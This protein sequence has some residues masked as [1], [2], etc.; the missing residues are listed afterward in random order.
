MLKTVFKNILDG[1]KNRLAWIDYARGIAIILVLYRHV[2]EGIKQ[3]GINV[4]RWMGLEHANIVFFSFRMPLFFIVSGVFM[5]GSL[6]KRGIGGFILNKAKLI[7]YPY[8]LWASL[9][10]TLQ[11]VFSKYVNGD[12]K[13]SDYLYILYAPREIEQFWYLYALFNVTILYALVKVKLNLKPIYQFILGAVMYYLSTWLV[14]HKIETYFIYDILHYYVF[15]A[16]G[17]LIADSIR[18]KETIAILSSWKTVL[19]LLPFFC[20][21]QYY[22]LTANLNSGLARYSFVEENQPTIYA[23]IA[24]TGCTFVVCVCHI[25]QRLEIGKWLRVVG[26]H[27]LYIYVSH[28]IIIAATRV[29]L[30][31]AL[32]INYVPLLLILGIISG[33]FFTIL[34]YQLAMKM[35]FWWLYSL[36]KPKAKNPSKSSISVNGEPATA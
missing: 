8:V 3:A 5:G 25:L 22:F 20:V 27:S 35:G 33:L 31:R 16:V 19:I 34:F 15:F 26:Y 12:R 1:G 2:F 24:L 32:G 11:L 29:F 30:S 9:Q 4:T 36:E 14:R 6:S 28:V 17:E 23:L 21:S 13:V 18:K 10:I 7:L